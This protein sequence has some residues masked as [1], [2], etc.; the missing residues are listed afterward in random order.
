MAYLEYLSL[1]SYSTIDII[2]LHFK[3]SC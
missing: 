2:H 3:V 1:I